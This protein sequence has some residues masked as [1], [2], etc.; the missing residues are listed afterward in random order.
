PRPG[1]HIATNPPVFVWKPH[2]SDDDFTLTVSRNKD[3]SDPVLMIEDYGEPVYLPTE[4]LKPG[5]YYWTWSTSSHRADVFSFEVPASAV[6]LEVPPA[7]EWVSRMPADHPRLFTRSEHLPG[8]REARHSEKADLWQKL[9][10]DADAVL[11]EPHETEEPPILPDRQ[12]DY[13]AW[14]KIWYQIMW[15]T[16]GF[17]KGAATLGL[18]YLAAERKAMRSPPAS[19][20]CRSQNGIRKG[21]VTWGTT[22]RPTCL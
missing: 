18:A 3:L 12:A 8:L 7:A 10:S 2:G 19:V 21:A 22:T 13:Q 16:R 11:T 17:V 4:A 15:G 9:K 6:V 1:A 5:T 14:F 20:W